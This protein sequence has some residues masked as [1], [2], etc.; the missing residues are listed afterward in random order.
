MHAFINWSI[1]N[2]SIYNKAA[3]I[4]EQIYWIQTQIDTMGNVYTKMFIKRISNRNQ[5]SLFLILIK[6]V[7]FM[8][9]KRI[10]QYI[11]IYTST[12]GYKTQTSYQNL[13]TAHRNTIRLWYAIL[14][15]YHKPRMHF[16]DI[17]PETY[18]PVNR[19]Y[20]NYSV[21]SMQYFRIIL[22]FESP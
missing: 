11:Y 7:I 3:Y 8:L 20:T 1:T 15:K 16:A 12:L 9:N 14:V 13:K 6:F 10:D 5:Q 19:V 17:R 21:Y 18:M 2:T 4:Q 22:S